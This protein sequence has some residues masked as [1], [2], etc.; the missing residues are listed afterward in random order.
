M[1]VPLDVT[2]HT[3]VLRQT[4]TNP[5]TYPTSMTECHISLCKFG[6]PSGYLYVT[7]TNV[8]GSA[9]YGTGLIEVA[10][11][12]A[13]TPKMLDIPVTWN[14]YTPS[15]API[16][17]TITTDTLGYRNELNFVA[18]EVNDEPYTEGFYGLG[19]CEAYDGTNWL[20]P[21]GRRCNMIS[22]FKFGRMASGIL[23]D[24]IAANTHAPYGLWDS[25]VGDVTEQMF[26]SESVTDW[27]ESHF[28]HW[29][30]GHDGNSFTLTNQM[31]NIRTD[32]NGR[33]FGNE[34]FAAA[35]TR[36]MG[37]SDI[38]TETQIVGYEWAKG[39]LKFIYDG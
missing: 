23:N 27:M 38:G 36:A 29:R 4:L 7:V 20:R 25:S 9:T 11:V 1:I 5:F 15:V 21:F 26:D 8:A 22:K 14:G 34:G 3:R 39:D 12:N 6:E 28:G 17:V 18:V 35:P 32:R 30:T 13:K 37:K 16:V 24:A 10:K 31:P 2:P 19:E 33:H